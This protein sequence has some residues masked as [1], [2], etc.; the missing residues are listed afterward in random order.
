M[1]D[2]LAIS[3]KQVRAAENHVPG[4]DAAAVRHP[5]GPRQ[6]HGDLAV[7]LLQ[8]RQRLQ[9]LATVTL[10]SGI[11]LNWVSGWKNPQSW[12][13]L[14]IGAAGAMLPLDSGERGH[15]PSAPSASDRAH[16][17]LRCRT[18]RVPGEELAVL[19][20]FMLYGCLLC[21]L[22]LAWLVLREGELAER[23]VCRRCAGQVVHDARGVGHGPSP[24]T[25]RT[26]VAQQVTSPSPVSA[27]NVDLT[28]GGDAGHLG[29][30]PAPPDAPPHGDPPPG[31]RAAQPPSPHSHLD[32]AAS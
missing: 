18:Q 19:P 27:H 21:R 7:N 29:Q 10:L 25:S 17:G 30:P 4:V 24:Q 28:S 13:A 14:T 5:D 20:L 12:L 3:G 23:Q 2:R 15:H 16:R 31:E 32:A 26:Q 22:F 11:L 9:R 1:R 6:V 8:G